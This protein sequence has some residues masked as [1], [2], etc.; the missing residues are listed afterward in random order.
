MNKPIP[1]DKVE[2]ITQEGILFGDV[3]LNNFLAEDGGIVPATMIALGGTSGAGKTT[4]CK[5]LQK[6]LPKDMISVFFSLETSK[7]SVA[8]Q[9]KRVKT[10]DNALVCDEN[11]FPKWSD[12]MAYLYKEKPTIAMVDSLQHAAKLLSKENGEY[13]Y[14]NYAK[15]VQ[16]LYD[17]KEAC[18]TSVI[19]IVQ[20]NAD[21]KVE[22]PEATVFDVDI[23]LKLI[24]DPKTGER[25]LEA[26]KNRNG[27]TVGR[28]FYEFVDNDKIIQFYEEDEYRVLKQ[29]V[30][31]S[32]MVIE[33]VERYTSAFKNHENYDSFK[34]EFNKEVKSIYNSNEDNTMICMEVVKL[35]MELST[36]HF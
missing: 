9:T 12:F 33:T 13:K 7:N 18:N 15:I 20:L 28:I 2:I 22:G 3:V 35:V 21:G 4:L 31:F 16:D 30:E 25:H 29:G 32:D 17:W 26:S 10:G 6:E 8:R 24:A 27:G 23:P 5:K 36:K 19:M 14:A 34:K 1:Y 11:D